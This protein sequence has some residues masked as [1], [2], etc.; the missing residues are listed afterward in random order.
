MNDY[1]IPIGFSALTAAIISGLYML[2]FAKAMIDQVRVMDPKLL[3]LIHSD[4]L[5]KENIKS[6]T[7]QVYQAGVRSTQLENQLINLSNE[8]LAIARQIAERKPVAT[9]IES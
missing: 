6:I 4:R 3:D 8:R 1:L 7:R 9:G 2:V 5:I